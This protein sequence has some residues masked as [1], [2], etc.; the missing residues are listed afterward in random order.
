MW[1]TDINVF[2]TTLS[3]RT[4][5]SFKKGEYKNILREQ[6]RNP[7]QVY[8]ALKKLEDATQEKLVAIFVRGE[9]D[10]PV[11]QHIA[12]GSGDFV[13]VDFKYLMRQALLILS[14]G[15]ILAHNHPSGE[16]YPSKEDR[17]VIHKLKTIAEFHDI[18]FIDFMIIG[19]HGYWSLME[20]EGQWFQLQKMAKR[21]KPPTLDDLEN[22]NRM[23]NVSGG[24]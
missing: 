16:A 15:F 22:L 24:V 10:D 3:Q 6:I 17:D 7:N 12:V 8:K 13:C 1:Y 18:T 11:Y 4:R 9:L 19:S 5:Y 14:S 2:E 20:E 21:L 23:K